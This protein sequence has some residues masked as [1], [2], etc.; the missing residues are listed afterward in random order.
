[1]FTFKGHDLKKEIS[2]TYLGVI[3]SGP[4]LNHNPYSRIKDGYWIGIWVFNRNNLKPWRV[5][6]SSFNFR[7]VRLRSAFIT[8]LWHLCVSLPGFS[9][10]V[11]HFRSPLGIWTAVSWL[12]QEEGCTCVTEIFMWGWQAAYEDLMEEKAQY[13]EWRTYMHACSILAEVHVIT[14]CVATH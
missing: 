1:M 11:R 8:P 6:V 5:D 3:L 12:P 10:L 13:H 9:N 2:C 14:W 7:I 4:S